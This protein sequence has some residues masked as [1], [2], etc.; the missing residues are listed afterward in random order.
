MDKLKDYLIDL[1]LTC[2]TC[3]EMIHGTKFEV[4]GGIECVRLTFDCPGKDGVAHQTELW[5]TDDDET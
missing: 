5:L 3:G 2:P 1:R 4:T